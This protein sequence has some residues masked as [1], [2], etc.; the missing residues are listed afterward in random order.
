MICLGNSDFDKLKFLACFQSMRERIFTSHNI[1][2]AFRKTGLF[3]FD[4]EQVLTKIRAAHTR[5]NRD[6]T[7][8]REILPLFAQTPHKSSEVLAHE[9]ALQE[10]IDSTCLKDLVDRYV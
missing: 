5:L 8:K 9:I 6:L 7:S 4:T 3:L 10:E 1:R 2:S